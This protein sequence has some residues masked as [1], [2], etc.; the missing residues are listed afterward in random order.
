MTNI[1]SC[2]Q[3]LSVLC[4]NFQYVKEELGMATSCR[5]HAYRGLVIIKS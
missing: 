5:H 2:L 3:K 4:G 1:D